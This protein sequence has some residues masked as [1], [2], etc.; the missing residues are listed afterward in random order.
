MLLVAFPTLLRVASLFTEVLVGSWL[1][2]SHAFGLELLSPSFKTPLF[3][4][5]S[6]VDAV[7]CDRPRPGGASR[8]C[9]GVL[10]HYSKRARGWGHRCHGDFRRSRYRLLHHAGHA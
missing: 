6:L 8:R 5:L 9:G 7:E 2:L 3:M 10:N 4:R 1:L